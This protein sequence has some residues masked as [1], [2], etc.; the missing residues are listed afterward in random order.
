[1]F[2][3]ESDKVVSGHADPV[4]RRGRGRPRCFDEQEA[5]HKA[6]L[7]FWEY[8]YEATSISDL[9]QALN[10]TAPSL[11]GSFGDKSQLFYRC[12]DYYLTTEA[13]PIERIFQEARTAR[14]AI[15]IYLHENIKKMVQEHKPAG[16]MLVVA[17]MNCSEQNHQIQEQLLQ[18]RHWVKQRIYERLQQGIQDQDL[19]PNSPIE[20]MA[21]FYTTIIQGMTLQARDGATIEQLNRVAEHAMKSWDTF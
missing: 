14:I 12:L 18:K 2:M 10:I 5:L 4:V 16:C 9:T 8:G 6:M 1:M 19:S 11:Y 17:T 7:L 15:E 13:C 20:A 21:D 3:T